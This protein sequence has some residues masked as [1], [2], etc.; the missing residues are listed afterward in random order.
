MNKVT[1]IIT[2]ETIV[3]KAEVISTL[4][5]PNLTTMRMDG[6]TT[7]QVDF[8]IQKLYEGFIIKVEDHYLMRKANERL[9]NLI[10]RRLELEHRLPYL[11]EKNKIEVD[12]N[13]LT[14]ELI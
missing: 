5:T 4:E 8:A 1:Q 3:E 10:L 13:K 6:N 2:I 7:R 14:I 11:Y 12:R 9:F